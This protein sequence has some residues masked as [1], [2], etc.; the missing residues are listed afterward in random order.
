[1]GCLDCQL[2][3]SP[4]LKKDAV[5][6]PKTSDRAAHFP[7]IEQ[8]Y[9]EPMSYWFAQMV[10][11]AEQKYPEQIAYLKENFGFSQVHA[12][13]LVMYS[14]GS[15]SAR[16][17]STVQEY[18]AQ[19]DAEKVRTVKRILKAITS[20][21]S[22]L[23]LVIAWNQPMLRYEGQYVF[24]VTVLK[25]HILLAPWSRDVLK[26]FAPRLK[27]YDVNKKTI[28]V[29]VDWKVDAKLLQ[30]MAKAR[31]AELSTHYP[32]LVRAAR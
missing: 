13:A 30:D 15:K 7:R 5:E 17:F 25:G 14:R 22:Q 29:P 9:G 1:M 6:P 20:K 31:L 4:L 21:Y 18:L 10:E 2:L 32:T 16:R 11:L 12:N 28:Q 23:E 26:K 8:K 24:G 19:F 3:Q 27:D